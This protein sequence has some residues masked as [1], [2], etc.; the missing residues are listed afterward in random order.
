MMYMYDMCNLNRIYILRN[1]TNS[2]F[3]AGSSF[4]VR[5]CSL[6]MSLCNPLVL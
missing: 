2:G 5:P 1:V 3:E 6:Y 4:N